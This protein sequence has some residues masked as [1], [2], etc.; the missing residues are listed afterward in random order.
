MA[1]L[2]ALALVGMCGTSQVL[3]QDA[4]TPTT[5][6]AP[7][8]ATTPRV[9]TWSDPEFEKVA[10]LLKGTWKSAAPVKVG[11]ES[12]E[13]VTSFAPVAIPEVPNAMYGEVA[14]ADALDRPYRQVILQLHRVKGKVRMKTMEFRRPK[15]ELLS[16][17]G[18]WAAPQAF[19]AVSMNEL[20]T[21]LDIELTTDGEGYKGATPHPY[22]TS[23]GGASEMTSEI[24][25]GPLQFQSADRGFGADGQIVWGPAS[26]ESYAFQR[27][28]SPIKLEVASDGLI[29]LT[30]PSAVEGKNFSEG[31]RITL[32]Y[33]GCMENGTIVDSS[34]ERNSPY[35][36]NYGQSTLIQG[37]VRA[38]QGA[39]KGLK[40]RMVVPGPLAYGDRGY[41]RA[42]IGPNATIIFAIDVLNVETPQQPVPVLAPPA[43]APA[44]QDPQ[45]K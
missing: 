15:G 4:P 33:V 23:A 7:A 20:V 2:L 36:Y 25:F 5:P 29:F 41:P 9:M 44:Q 3:A 10:G 40:R 13:V 8:M 27:V 34:Y 24:A 22:P 6:T 43:P 30:Y 17:I 42:K 19:P 39:Q 32:H 14:R 38:M 26:G 45:G 31:D 18:L 16:V 21:T 1:G 12:F 35:S 28:E 37:W 11:A